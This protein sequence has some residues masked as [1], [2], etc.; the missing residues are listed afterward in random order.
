MSRQEPVFVSVMQNGDFETFQSFTQVEPGLR[1]H[2]HDHYEINCVLEG[3]G[4]FHIAGHEYEC[5]AGTVFLINPGVVH[6]VV[7]QLSERYVR[8]YVHV[9]PKF[10]A[11]HSTTQTDLE[12]CFQ[13]LDAPVN[14][15]LKLDASLLSSLLE[16]LCNPQP[17]GAFGADVLNTAAM[18]EFM[19]VIN[20]ACQ[21]T[22]REEMGLP[23]EEEPAGSYCK[24][25]RDALRFIDEHLTSD[26]SL[27]TIAQSCFVSKYYLSREFK[28]EVG[29]NLSRY[30]LSRRLRYSRSLLPELES[31]K[32]VYR[33]CG[34]KSYTHFLRC[35]QNE[36]G[37]TTSQYL[38]SSRRP[39]QVDGARASVDDK[40]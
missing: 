26:L 2:T 32:Q 14:R 18:L 33:L 10:L 34:F 16:P 35:F 23:L 15:I 24:A 13:Q 31:P 21:S 7:E 40:P 29:M 37:M 12:S 11:A 6:N 19:V 4:R 22:V 17:A 1:L 39:A 8:C 9:T 25:V 36:F 28:K 20:R 38:A 5:E 30:V 3:R 27:E